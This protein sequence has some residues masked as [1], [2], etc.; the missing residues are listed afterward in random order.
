[1]EMKKNKIIGFIGLILIV[2]VSVVVWQG[3]TAVSANGSSNIH[4]P[5]VYN[6]HDATLSI[7]VFGVQTYGDIQPGSTYYDSLI[8]TN[9]SWLRNAVIWNHVEPINVT[10]DAYNW[11]STDTRFSVARQDFGGVN[12][13]GTIANNPAWAA[14]AQQGVLYPTALNDFAE[15]ISALVERYD[16]DGFNDAPGSP[17]IN[18]WEFYNEPDNS[19]DSIGNPNY[20]EP[21]HWGDHGVEYANMLATIYPVVK[22]ANPQA[23]V[24]LG[25]LALDWF[26]DDGGPFVA[27]F[28][29]DVLAAGGGNYF[30]VMNFHS[31]PAFYYNWTNNFGPGLLGKAEY[32]RG[33]LA[34]HGWEKPMVVTEAGWM[35]NDTPGSLIPGS[36]EIQSRY[37]VE[38]FTESMAADLDMMIWWLLFDPSFPYP[39]MNGLVTQPPVVPKMSYYVYQN[40]VAEL[41]TAHFVRSLSTNETGH[42]L[43][44]A[45]LF[46]DNVLRR[47]LYVAWLNP[48]TS[49]ETA[50]LHITAPAATVRDSLTG[51]ATLV[52]DGDDGSVDGQITV[53]VG[54]NPLY[55][56]VDQ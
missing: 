5:L 9:A 33:I 45:Y 25:G 50:L 44:E 19:S 17:V 42:S 18:Y 14:P 13:I 34:N 36:P 56:E 21:M 43:M 38:L 22:A 8:G 35:S 15:F 26:E 11:A 31:Y 53:N 12:I 3:G 4:L 47:E 23:Q 16:G 28:L 30:D 1:M 6:N 27:S 54:A 46:N 41:G 48:V 37:V 52:Q 39:S 7:P 32:V 40:V 20:T 29:D 55:V 49:S 2:M 10:P 51:L 24:V